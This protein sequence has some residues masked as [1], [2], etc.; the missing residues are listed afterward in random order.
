MSTVRITICIPAYNRAEFLQPLLTSVLRELDEDVEVLVCEDNSPQKALIKE[1]IEK[2]ESE[3]CVKIR[4]IENKYNLG[5]DGNLRKLINLAKGD[6]C[7]FLGNDDILC[8]GA[9][10][11]I[12]DIVNSYPKCGVVI[13]SYGTFEGPDNRIKEVYRYFPNEVH[14]ESGSDAIIAAFRRSVVIPGM[15]IHRESALKLSTNRFDGT[16]LYQL[17]LVGCILS[18]RDVI[19]TPK[20]IALRREG[21]A[22]DF[23]NSISEQGHFEPGQQTPESSLFF[24]AGMLK[25]ARFVEQVTNLKVYNHILLDLGAYSYPLLSIQSNRS[26]ATFY[27]YCFG[28][29]KQG[30]WKSHWFF[31]YFLVLRLVGQRR[32]NTVIGYLKTKIGHT[33]RIGRFRKFSK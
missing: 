32:M 28:L 15:V 13:R 23:G 16:L 5:Y 21:V 4:F 2:F 31:I 20:V 17:Y 11:S 9:I 10:S 1:E 22:P 14:M 6:Y 30:L 19:F 27:R 12:K 24:V 8:E 3:N 7:L 25:I 29:A 18:E 26:A 33:P